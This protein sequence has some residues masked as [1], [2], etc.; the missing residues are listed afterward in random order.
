MTSIHDLESKTEVAVWTDI[1]L[2][3]QWDVL[4]HVRTHDHPGRHM[5]TGSACV[6]WY[7]YRKGGVSHCVCDKGGR[8]NKK[9]R[10][11]TG[12]T[13]EKPTGL[14][15]GRFPTR[16]AHWAPRGIFFSHARS[17]LGFSRSDLVGLF[18]LFFFSFRSARTET[19]STWFAFD[20]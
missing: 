9:K 7:V 19:I 16:E 15:A 5:F 1:R 13:R 4:S 3:G 14:L 11:E 12:P 2:F 18:F 6:E 17:P 10:P 8:H 20:E